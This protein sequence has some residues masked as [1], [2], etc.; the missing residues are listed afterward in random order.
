VE[1]DAEGMVLGINKAVL[2]EEKCVQLQAGD[3][4]LLYTDGITEAQNP[5]GEFFGAD[6]L[7]EVFFAQRGEPPEAAIGQILAALRAFSAS[8]SFNDDVSMAV[9]QVG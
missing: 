7:C 2:F 8:Q 9:L 3:R 4:V 1:L 6:R 5:A